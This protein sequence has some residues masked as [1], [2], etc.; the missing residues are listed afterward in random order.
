MLKK[1]E[2]LKPEIEEICDIISDMIASSDGHPDTK[3]LIYRVMENKGKMIRPL[4]L[5]LVAGDIDPECGEELLSLAAS[6]ELL[7]NSSLLFDD[8]IDNSSIRRSKPTVN[9]LYGNGVA[10]TGG[11]Y[12]LATAVRYMQERGFYDSAIDLVRTI[13]HASDG[14]MIQNKNINNTKVDIESYMSAIKG[15]TAYIFKTCAYASCRITKASDER[16]KRME[17]F[18]EN[19]GIMFQIR[20]DLLDWTMDEESIGKPTDEDFKEGIYTLPAIYTFSQDRFGDELKAMIK[21][22]NYSS[23]EIRNTVRKAGGIDYTV[24]CLN[25]YGKRAKEILESEPDNKYTQ[26]MRIIVD[27]LMLEES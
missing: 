25:D 6:I 2:W 1:F 12:I 15:K 21:S 22:G 9:A 5:L 18:G 26:A 13:Q 23:D 10:I 4:L 27:F 14:E 20:D 17:K 7:H 19:I 11:L 24:N 16:R 8:V 3:E